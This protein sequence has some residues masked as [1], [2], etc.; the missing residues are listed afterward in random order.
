MLGISTMQLWTGIFRNTQSKSQKLSFNWVFLYLLWDALQYALF[1]S[2][3]F[4]VLIYC[5]EGVVSTNCE[6][7]VN[8]H[9]T[10]IQ[11]FYYYVLR[12]IEK[13]IINLHS[14]HSSHMFK[15]HDC[16][17]WCLSLQ[18]LPVVMIGGV[19]RHDVLPNQRILLTYTRDLT[20]AISSCQ[21]GVTVTMDI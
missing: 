2:C 11:S 4:T 12:K 14:Q 7:Q 20:P 15:W 19:L 8:V 1:Y 17:P 9:D 18:V 21:T 10:P 3:N 6:D 16:Q 13:V 5:V